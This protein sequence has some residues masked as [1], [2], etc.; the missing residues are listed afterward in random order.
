MNSLIKEEHKLGHRF[1]AI[2]QQLTVSDTFYY[3]LVS[4]KKVLM[5]PQLCVVILWPLAVAVVIAEAV[6]A[7]KAY[8]G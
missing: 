7:F 2:F 8:I 4:T 5:F 1:D 6:W 3:I